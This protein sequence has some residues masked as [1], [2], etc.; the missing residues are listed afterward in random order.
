MTP[1]C[2]LNGRKALEYRSRNQA[3]G[4]IS[5]SFDGFLEATSLPSELSWR[6]QFRIP[7]DCSNF[8]GFKLAVTVSPTANLRPG[9]GVSC[10]EIRDG[11]Y[12]SDPPTPRFDKSMSFTSGMMLHLLF[13]EWNFSK[14]KFLERG[15]V[16]WKSDPLASRKKREKVKNTIR[17]DG[18]A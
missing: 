11:K 7:T 9:V 13:D 14:A 3:L 1:P 4:F 12:F 10:K 16:N 2:L 6:Y 8:H 17:L 18:S 5:A 15:K